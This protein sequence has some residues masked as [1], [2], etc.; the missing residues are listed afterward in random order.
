MAPIA[1]WIVL[2]RPKEQILVRFRV[3]AIIQSRNQKAERRD[4]A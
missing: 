2:L 1:Q 4:K 3:G